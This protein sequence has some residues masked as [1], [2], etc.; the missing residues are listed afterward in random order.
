MPDCSKR[1]LACRDLQA[2]FAKRKGTALMKNGLV[3]KGNQGQ[4]EIMWA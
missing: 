1:H 4:V 3:S 2:V